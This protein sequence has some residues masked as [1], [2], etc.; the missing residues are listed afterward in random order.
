MREAGA[1]VIGV[2][3]RVPL[4]DAWARVGFDAAVQGNLDP[5][6]CLAPW[7][8]VRS[9]AL[10]VLERAGGRPGHVFNLGHGILPGT[11][12]ETIERLVDLVHG[13]P[14]G[15]RAEQIVK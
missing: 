14:V 13:H 8:A 10:R 9:K 5:A 1:T 11:P 15:A 6:A 12:P 3:W 4:E 2:D 7:G